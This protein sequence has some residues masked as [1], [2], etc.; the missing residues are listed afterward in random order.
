MKS[1]TLLILTVSAAL[2]MPSVAAA[3]GP[4]GHQA[5]Q[6]KPKPQSCAQLADT[7]KYSVDLGDPETK[8]LKQ[9]CDKSKA[10]A[11]K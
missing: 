6:K 7:S 1:Y 3:H 11:K 2:A 10:P 8:A 9:S 4:N 5:E